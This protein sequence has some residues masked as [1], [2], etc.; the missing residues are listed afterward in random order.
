MIGKRWSRK[1]FMLGVAGSGL[2]MLVGCGDDEPAGDGDTDGSG[3]S[4]GSGSSN[5]AAGPSSSSGQSSSG[6]AS[7][8]GGSVSSSS[9]SG[10]GGEATVTCAAMIVAVISN[11]H[12][13]ALSIPLA[14]IEAGADMTYSAMGTATHCHEVTLTAADFATLKGGGSVTKFSC[15]GGDHEYVLSCAPDAPAPGAPDCDADPTA[16]SC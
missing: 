8:S 6:P 10:A 7:G 1:D 4:G 15:N 9:S 14:D 12:G 11:N 16:G 2:A 5:G 13:H 3:G